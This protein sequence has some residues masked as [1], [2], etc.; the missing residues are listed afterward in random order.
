MRVRATRQHCGREFLSF[1]LYGA[2]PVRCLGE[3]TARIP[4]FR[5]D[6]DGPLGPIRDA[7]MALT[8]GDEA[9]AEHRH[10]GNVGPLR[11][12]WQRHHQAAA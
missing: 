3:L 7:V 2:E 11:W 9:A 10:T 5:V 4:A 12:P 6:P 8:A 1:Q